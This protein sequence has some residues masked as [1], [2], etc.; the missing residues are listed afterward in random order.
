M[1]CS[2]LVVALVCSFLLLPEETRA[3]ST[4]APSAACPRIFPEG[5]GV[6]SQD[7]D[8]SPYT[9]DISAFDGSYTPG[10]TYTCK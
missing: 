10:E 8:T 5:H 6:Q 3:R 4:G 9:L 1:Y 7:L 2:A